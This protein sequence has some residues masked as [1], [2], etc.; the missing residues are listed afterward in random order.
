M[1]VVLHQITFLA[2]VVKLRK[3]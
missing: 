2:K 1:D 3:Y